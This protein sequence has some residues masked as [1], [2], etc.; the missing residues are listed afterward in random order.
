[1]VVNRYYPRDGIAKDIIKVDNKIA[2][3]STE[4]F[5]YN[6]L[7]LLIIINNKKYIPPIIAASVPAAICVGYRITCPNQSAQIINVAPIML[8]TNNCCFD[9]CAPSIIAM[10]GATSPTNEMGPMVAVVIEHNSATI[11]N[12]MILA[13]DAFK[14]LAVEKSRPIEISVNHLDKL[15]AIP[16]ITVT[17]S[18]NVDACSPVTRYVDPDSHCN[19][20]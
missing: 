18:A 2:A 4:Y 13:C 10:W 16:P 6:H 11:T 8:P 14:P 3:N 17:P 19:M 1:M 9:F 15:K 7:T 5:C 12:K 20:L